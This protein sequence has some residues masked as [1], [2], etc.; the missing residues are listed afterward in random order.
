M[1]SSFNLTLSDKEQSMRSNL[2]LPHFEMQTFDQVQQQ[3]N[4]DG[5]SSDYDDDLEI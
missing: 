5:D 1:Q 4:S 3:E 2:L